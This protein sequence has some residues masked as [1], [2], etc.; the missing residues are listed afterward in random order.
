MFLYR[1]AIAGLFRR[2][3]VLKSMDRKE[4]EK[5][6]GQLRHAIRKH[7]QLYYEQAAPIISDRE[8]DQLYKELVDLET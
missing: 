3:I 1:P 7:D 5:K 4:T 6:I 8:Y 2:R